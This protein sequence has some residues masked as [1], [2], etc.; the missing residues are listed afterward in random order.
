M[1]NLRIMIHQ[2]FRRVLSI[3]A[4]LLI[5]FALI[6]PAAAAPRNYLVIFVFDEDHYYKKA[7][8]RFTVTSEIETPEKEGYV[9]GGWY[10]DQKYE[11]L[12]DFSQPVNEPFYLYAKW[13][14]ED[15][16]K[17]EPTTN[18]TTN[19]TKN[20]S[21]TWDSSWGFTQSNSSSAN[22]SSSNPQGMPNPTPRPP[23]GEAE[24]PDP[25]TFIPDPATI[26]FLVIA[27]LAAAIVAYFILSKS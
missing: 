22:N 21:S 25:I 27:G 16:A 12:Y 2:K 18:S 7:V 17:T 5:L 20:S 1:G 8:P 3:F 19:S 10:L 9:F 11:E 15:S 24:I 14:P 13:I 6:G 4:I 23:Q 26:A